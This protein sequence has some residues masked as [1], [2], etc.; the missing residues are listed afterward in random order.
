MIPAPRRIPP[1]GHLFSLD[2]NNPVQSLIGLACEHGEI[3]RLKLPG[4][5]LVVVSSR[6][7]V[8]EL[9]DETRFDKKLHQPL[10]RV[11]DFAGDG[12]I[13][14][15]TREPNWPLAHRILASAFNPATLRAMF[16]PM[17]DLATQLVLKWE[18]HGPAA[19]IDLTD[20]MTR[21]T[22]DTI[23]LC[24][25]GHRLNSF[26]DRELHPF[27]GAMFRALTESSARVRRPPGVGHFML[28]TKARY[29]DDIR[30]MH[31]LA[32]E[33]IANRRRRAGSEPANVLDIMLG[34]PDPETGAYLDHA[35]IRHQLVTFLIAGHETTSGLLSFALYEL[36]RSPKE[37]ARARDEV[38]RV[39]RGRDPGFD[40]LPK[41]AFV[42]QVLKETLRLWP[43]APAF[44]YRSKA[45][46]TTIGGR[47]PVTDQHTILVLLPSLHRDPTVWD[48]PED[49]LPDR[50]RHDRFAALPPHAWKPFGNGQ[51]ACIGRAF[52][53]QE[54]TLALAMILQRFDLTFADS[55]YRLEIVESLTTK[56]KDLFIHARPR[57]RVVPTA[58]FGPSVVTPATKPIT[59]LHASRGGTAREYAERLATRLA[60]LGY[61]AQVD[62]IDAGFRSATGTVIFIAASYN[63]RAA[64]SAR[65][66]CAHLEGAKDL[67][68]DEFAVF[69]CGNRDWARTYQAV[70][71]FIDDR[72][73]ALGVTP[74]LSRGEGDSRSDSGADFSRWSERLVLALTNRP[75]L[76]RLGIGAGHLDVFADPEFD[77]PATRAQLEAL[78]GFIACPPHRA[79]FDRRVGHAS[80]RSVF[81][82]LADL[83]SCQISPEHLLGILRGHRD[84]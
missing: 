39:L 1:F 33:I 76:R 18:R 11:R 6:A 30:T 84:L 34:T 35:N 47:Y 69:G 44:A 81:D 16:E 49:F 36:L 22:V 40:D 75:L 50:M 15:D 61:R 14:A 78:A 60:P 53:L 65:D 57:V 20:D 68:F 64:E 72:L 71:K 26:Y 45:P 25:F 23:A 51:R 28:R 41:L 70:P 5:T 42:D 55:G 2:L 59:I 58:T 77:R 13:T 29:R 80:E 19:R 3:F 54:A 31:R 12:L 38:D 82:W 48:R 74:I 43:T 7:L 24:A 56:P 10:E 79:E 67:T 46:E 27:V 52:A 62:T 21:L 17:R 8:A 32:D 37:L 83:P 9:S 73:R 66:F 63:G 4:E